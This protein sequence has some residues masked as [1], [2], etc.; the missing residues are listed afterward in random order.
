MARLLRGLDDRHLDRYAGYQF[1]ENYQYREKSF[2][3]H[4]FMA[5][6]YSRLLLHKQDKSDRL[7]G[8]GKRLSR[9]R[10]G[11]FKN[12]ARS[13]YLRATEA[14][15]YN[16]D[17]HEWSRRQKWR[18]V[19]GPLYPRLK[20]SAMCWR[21][22]SRECYGRCAYSH[23]THEKMAERHANWLRRFKWLQ[24]ILAALTTGGA[25]TVLFDRNSFFFAFATALLA[26][27]LLIANS[28]MKDLDPGQTAE[29][30]REAASE[31]GMFGKRI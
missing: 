27:L 18:E 13:A 20:T 7:A 29:K 16:D 23:K 9:R 2:L 3:Y 4:D 31:S 5:R 25:V 22:G 17:N 1:I 15:K 12:K 11:E 21:V 6:D 19:F 10:T 30:H 8:A 14:I 24:I 26:I 28:Y